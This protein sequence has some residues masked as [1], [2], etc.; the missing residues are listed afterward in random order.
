MVSSYVSFQPT[1]RAGVESR[2]HPAEVE[3]GQISDAF[4]HGLWSRP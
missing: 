1:S 2:C 4:I 3:V